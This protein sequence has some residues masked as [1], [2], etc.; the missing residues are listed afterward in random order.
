MGLWILLFA[1]AVAATCALA[2]RDRCRPTARLVRAMRPSPGTGRTPQTRATAGTTTAA[3]AV[4]SN[5]HH[6]AREAKRLRL[7]PV[8][9]GAALIHSG[10]QPTRGEQHL[11]RLMGHQLPNYKPMISRYAAPTSTPPW[12]PPR[13][14]TQGS[15]Q[16]Y[17]ENGQ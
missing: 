6:V 4:V 2:R 12:L 1:I 13:R 5:V 14:T 8:L 15:Q 11:V 7:G 16:V 3:A 9:L 17:Q 10:E